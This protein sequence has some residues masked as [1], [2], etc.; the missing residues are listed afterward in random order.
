[1]RISWCLV[2]RVNAWMPVNI[3]YTLNEDTEVSLSKCCRVNEWSVE[4]VQHVV[5]YYLCQLS[6]DAGKAC[7]Q[8]LLCFQSE[9][10]HVRTDPNKQLLICWPTHTMH[11][12]Q[13]C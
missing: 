8:C 5:C 1:M 3:E 10:M 2:L 12:S 6:Q 9:V 7:W 4:Y 13:F 11:R